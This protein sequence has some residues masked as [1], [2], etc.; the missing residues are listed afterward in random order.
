MKASKLLI[1]AALLG[2]AL[3]SSGAQAA[4]VVVGVGIGPVW[5][6]WYPYP[7]G[8]PYPYAYPYPYPAAPAV[9]PAPPAQTVYVENPQAA[10]PAPAANTW[11][12]CRNPQGYYPY[13]KQCSGAWEPVPA[14]PPASH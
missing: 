9:L 11:Y 7:V 5:G 14:Q 6:P 3:L 4:R 13:V 1:L 12:F 10:A 2:G 8:Y